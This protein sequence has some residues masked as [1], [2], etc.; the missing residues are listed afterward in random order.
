MK[1]VRVKIAK[2]VKIK[3][4][5]INAPCANAQGA[6]IMRGS[7][8][9]APKG[10]LSFAD[11]GAIRTCSQVS[12]RWFSSNACGGYFQHVRNSPPAPFSIRFLSF[13]RPLQRCMCIIGHLYLK[14]KP[15]TK[16]LTALT[17]SKGHMATWQ[18][19]PSLSQSR[20]GNGHGLR[21][22]SCL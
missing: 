9:V 8:L 21:I 6:Q 14:V 4:Q 15:S 2:I 1:I 7:T 3:I 19:L 22:Q 17:A 11:N 13:T 10:S 5:K 16:G 12:R 18:D 20:K